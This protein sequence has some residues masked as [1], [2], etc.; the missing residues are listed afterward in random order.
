MDGHFEYSIRYNIRFY[1]RGKYFNRAKKLGIEILTNH[2]VVNLAKSEKTNS[3]ALVCMCARVYMCLYVSVFVT[4]VVC[5]LCR[6]SVCV[7][8]PDNLG[9]ISVRWTKQ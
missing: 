9:T 6:G 1:L 4:V 7:C 8:E 2:D 5:H 3:L